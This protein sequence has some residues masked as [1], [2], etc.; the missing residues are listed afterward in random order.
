MTVAGHLLD[1]ECREPALACHARSLNRKPCA[2]QV[3]RD[4]P[5]ETPVTDNARWTRR[6]EGSTWGDYGPADERGR[7]NLLTPEIVLQDIAE[8]KLGKTFCLSVPLDYPGDAVL[9]PRRHP[10]VLKPTMRGDKPNM[11][12]PLRWPRDQLCPG[13]KY[14][15]GPSTLLGSLRRHA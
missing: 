13:T 2:P 12:Y 9:S 7:L 11:N 1:A 6:P 5:E 14:A 4:H 3:S 15:P 8:V 10:P